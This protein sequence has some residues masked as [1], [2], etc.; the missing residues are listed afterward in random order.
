[1]HIQTRIHL[2]VPKNYCNLFSFPFNVTKIFCLFLFF[3]DFMYLFL[4]RGEGKLKERDRNFTVWLP[5]LHPLL[6]TWPLTQ[7]CALTGNRTS[8]LLVCRSVLN[9]LNHTSQGLSW[10]YFWS[11][12]NWGYHFSFR[13]VEFERKH[14]K[15]NPE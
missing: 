12:I 1:M 9:P 10:W 14:M 6:W 13:D 8:D 7:A 4:E 5:L 15:M 2:L 11:H 3:K